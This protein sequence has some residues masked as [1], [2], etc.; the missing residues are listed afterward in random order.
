MFCSATLTWYHTCKSRPPGAAT[1]QVDQEFRGKTR[2]IV[3]AR[4]LYL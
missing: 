2:E 1:A 3:K 4:E